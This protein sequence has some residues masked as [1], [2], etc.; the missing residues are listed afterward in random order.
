[1]ATV[2]ETIDIAVPVRTAYDQWTQFEEFPSFMEDIREVRQ[3]DATHL[4]WVAELGGRFEEWDAV[5]TEQRPDEC[6]AWRSTGGRR[7]AGVVRFA[8]LGPELTRVTV[9]LEHE[10]DGVIEAVG[11]AVGADDRRVR[12]DLERFRDTIEA[13][14]D[15]TGAWRGRVADDV[16]ADGGAPAPHMD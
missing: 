12:R 4:H 11:S 13:R 6:V 9:E 8:A 1:M 16:A 3:L 10:T 2:S 14:G 7:N 15:A 5:I